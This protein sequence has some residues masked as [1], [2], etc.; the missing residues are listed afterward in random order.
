MPA[1]TLKVPYQV[2]DL[3]RQLHPDL[4]RK[5][6]AALTDILKDPA[7]GKPLERELRGYWS[8]QVGRHRVI[9]RPDEGGVEIVAVGP[10][11]TIYE[12]AAREILRS[13]GRT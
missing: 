11:R 6:R 8:L 10:R 7:C 2:R 5:V 3:V 13:K 9:Y 1:P 4:K 12:D